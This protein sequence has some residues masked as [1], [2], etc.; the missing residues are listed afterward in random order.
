MQFIV[1][2]AFTCVVRILRHFMCDSVFF[3]DINTDMSRI[4][5]PRAFIRDDSLS[6][7]IPEGDKHRL[8][9]IARIKRRD[10]S[11]LALELICDGLSAIE[12]KLATGETHGR[13]EG[14]HHL[15]S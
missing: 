2:K 11:N 9:R 8:K 6:I 4:K 3:D 15:P 10:T 7:R 12:S 1:A 14:I 13:Q 5:R